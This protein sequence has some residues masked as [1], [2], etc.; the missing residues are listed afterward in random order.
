[1][2]AIFDTNILIDYLKGYTVASEEL[3]RFEVKAISIITYIEIL[4][5]LHDKSVI[6]SVKNFLNSLHIVPVNQKIADLS[7]IARKKYKLKVPDAII[8]AT[9]QSLDALLITRNTKDF[10][11]SIPIVRIPY[12]L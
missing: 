5:G 9:A 12:N 4:V 7:V 3:N 11:P 6:E 10:P 8:F 2:K 1:M